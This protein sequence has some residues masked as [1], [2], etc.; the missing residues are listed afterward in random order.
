MNRLLMR[1]GNVKGGQFLRD[2][3]NGSR[4]GAIEEDERFG[5]GRMVLFELALGWEALSELG[6]LKRFS[7]KNSQGPVRVIEH[8]Y[9]ASQR[10]VIFSLPIRFGLLASMRSSKSQSLQRDFCGTH[11]YIIGYT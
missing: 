4:E 7:D 9:V 11:A 6:I 8:L 10:T 5:H 2:Q 1:G 3:A